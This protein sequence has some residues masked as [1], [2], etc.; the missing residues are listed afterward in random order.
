MFVF[1][2]LPEAIDTADGRRHEDK[3]N[4]HH[5]AKGDVDHALPEQQAQTGLLR[6]EVVVQV[7]KLDDVAVA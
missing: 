3:K 6:H 7:S 2:V 1:N 5:D 4:P